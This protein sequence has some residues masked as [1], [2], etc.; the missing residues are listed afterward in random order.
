AVDR[1]YTLADFLSV[2]DKPL[3]REGYTL[4][5]TVDGKETTDPNFVMKDDQQI[6]LEYTRSLCFKISFKPFQ[7]QK[8]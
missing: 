5:M 3:L 1:G 2:W 4:K 6:V 8:K 7:R